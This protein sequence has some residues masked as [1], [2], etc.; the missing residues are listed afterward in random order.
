VGFWFSSA[1][2]FLIA[3]HAMSASIAGTVTDGESGEPIAGA[4]VSLSDLELTAVTDSSGQYVFQGV[5]AGPQ[6]VSVQRIGYSPRTLHA[7]VPR[8]GT[9]EINIAL[10]PEPIAHQAIE[11]EVR[12]AVPVRGLDEDDSTIFPDRG[13]SLA[14][15]RAHPLSAEPDAFEA[16]GGGEVVVRPETPSGLHIRGGASDQVT[17]LLD[18]IPVFSPYHVTGTFSAWNPDALSRLE[19][20]AAAPPPGFPESL[21]GA[22]LGWTRTPGSQFRTQG[23][24][25]TTQ[26]R[27]TIDGPLGPDGAGYLF[28]LRRA[29]PGVP[30]PKN[31]PS[32]VRGENGD[33]LAKVESPLFDG[34]IRLLA[35]DSESDIGS[36][37]FVEPEVAGQPE[38]AG[39]SET[40]D[41]PEADRTRNSFEWHS[42][43]IGGEWSWD[44]GSAA[45]RF[46]GWSALGDADAVWRRGL[47]SLPELLTSKRRDEGLV[48]MAEMTT[49]GRT[50]AAGLR[51]QRSR[52][53]Y[54]FGADPGDEVSTSLSTRTPVSTAFVQHARPL[55]ASTDL[56]L[57]LAGSIAAGDLHLSPR[58]QLRWRPSPEVSV[59]G[60]YARLHQFAQSLRNSESV[61]G[62]IFPADLYVGA[63]AGVPV[64]RSH[65]GIVA[66][67]VRPTAGVR[68]GVQAYA[69]EFDRLVLV[70]P[71]DGD[72]F[73]TSGFVEGSGEAQGAAFE[74][75]ANGARYGIIAAYGLQ[76]V[77][78]E[79]ADTRYVPDYGPAHSLEGG[80]TLF[81]STTSSARLG[82]TGVF[83]RHTTP[84]E[85][86]I[87][88]EACN[89]LDHGCEFSGSPQ[90]PLDSLGSTRL[91]GYLRVDVGIAKHWHLEL[92]GREGLVSLFGTLSNVFGRKNVLTIATHPATGELTELTMRPLSPLVVGIDWRF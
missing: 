90:H 42:R 67:E 66:L 58:A 3:A 65:Q 8:E 60:S 87:E 55:T 6:H 38:V 18:G 24:T 91:P 7:L 46:R 43:S 2:T 16:L 53:S 33:W 89:L 35:Y 20:L 88:W 30:Y 61:V 75:G 49:E 36:A 11:V 52:T 37:A 1:A 56:E 19:L 10:R 45:I 9:I 71:R 13:L 76:R 54:R 23:S 4:V 84:I 47:D 78:L 12:P 57:A 15:V 29:F 79:S 62:N 22:V 77:R 83:G 5:P 81:P 31:E 26:A 68:F 48:A 25:S 85:G 80:I 50:T 51:I 44:L 69:R 27:V 32:Y 34:R 73:A 92:A 41:E 59:S 74:A 40:S 17:Y 21:S 28:S 63:G 39:D 14:A 82:V 64:A 70:A 86:L 72:P